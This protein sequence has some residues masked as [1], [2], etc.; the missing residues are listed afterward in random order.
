MIQQQLPG[1]FV[2]QV[3]YVGGEGH[4]L[5]DKY[6]VNLIDPLTGLRPLTSS[7]PSA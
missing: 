7:A 1:A 6:T 5:F 4:H 2:G 3:G